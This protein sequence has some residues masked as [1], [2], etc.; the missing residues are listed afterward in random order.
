VIPEI[1]EKFDL[2]FI[3]G[4]KEQYIEYYEAVLPKLRTGGF[5]LVDNVLWSGK[6]LPDNRDNDKETVCIREF[7]N[8]IKKDKRIEKLLLPFRDGIYILRTLI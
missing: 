2:V 5:I 8:F 4:D 3:D 1:T 6:V 7:N